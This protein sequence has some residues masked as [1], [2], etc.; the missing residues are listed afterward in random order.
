MQC[1]RKDLYKAVEGP[2]TRTYRPL[3]DQLVILSPYLLQFDQVLQVSQISKRCCRS[4]RLKKT[5]CT[6]QKVVRP[7]T[8]FMD[9][10]QF[11]RLLMRPIQFYVL[12]RCK[13]NRHI[14][15]QVIPAKGTLFQYLLWWTRYNNQLFAGIL[16]ASP[17]H[18]D[19][20]AL[21]QAFILV[22]FQHQIFDCQE[23]GLS[24]MWQITMDSSS[25]HR[26]GASFWRRYTYQG[27]RT[28]WRM[29]RQEEDPLISL[30]EKMWN[31]YSDIYKLKLQT[32]TFLQL[33]ELKS[34]LPFHI[35]WH[36][37]IL[38]KYSEKIVF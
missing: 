35:Q 23:V 27:K 37:Q 2:S 33:W 38:G 5:L 17:L 8:S 6:A 25:W 34:A 12:W 22:S 26:V 29:T 7:K 15:Y 24:Q 4:C 36:G 31:I 13:P 10:T 18:N 28:F 19:L 9:L 20:I 21:K 3:G 11:C 32:Q 1:F 30:S 16:L 14:I